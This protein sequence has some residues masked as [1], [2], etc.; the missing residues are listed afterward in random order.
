MRRN[1][2]ITS[3]SVSMMLGNWKSRGFIEAVEDDGKVPKGMR[4]YRK[5]EE[6]LSRKF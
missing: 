4:R 3:G 5:T 6:Y 1:R 2:Q